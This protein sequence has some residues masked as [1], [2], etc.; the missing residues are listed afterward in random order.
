MSSKKRSASEG[1]D[2]S[3]IT[4]E[5]KRLD[6][7]TRDEL[8]LD[9]RGDLED[10]GLNPHEDSEEGDS[11]RDQGVMDAA[12]DECDH[13][14]GEH[15]DGDGDAVDS[16]L[17]EIAEDLIE[18]GMNPDAASNKVYDI[19]AELVDGDLVADTPEVDADELAKVNW[20][21]NAVPKIREQ[22]QND[23]LLPARGAQYAEEG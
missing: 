10:V 14:A 7:V 22:L 15:I 21:A 17:L 19:L 3:H 4:E 16:A 6:E 18:R 23:G 8:D 1:S 20:V 11:P 9:D 2:W 13:E 5:L 12:D